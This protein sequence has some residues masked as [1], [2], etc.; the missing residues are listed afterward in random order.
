MSIS[1]LE[2]FFA[3]VLAR[4]LPMAGSSSILLTTVC[5]Y[6][7][8]GK[9]NS[10]NA[11]TR[12]VILEMTGKLTPSRTIMTYTSKMEILCLTRENFN[13]NPGRLSLKFV[14]L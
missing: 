4:I 1:D 3:D 10:T 14:S 7:M 9:E 8:L 13:A 5:G 2:D 6:R 11:P 12:I